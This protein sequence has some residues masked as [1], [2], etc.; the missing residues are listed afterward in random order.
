MILR[1]SKS[2]AIGVAIT[3]VA[4]VFAGWLGHSS[5]PFLNQ[6]Y[7][8]FSAPR[9]EEGFEYLTGYRGSQSF[10]WDEI[11][12]SK[13]FQLSVLK[14]RGESPQTRLGLLPRST[15]HRYI[16][17]DPNLRDSLYLMQSYA[18]ASARAETGRAALTEDFVPLA[19]AFVAAAK[20]RGIEVSPIGEIKIASLDVGSW[21]IVIREH[22]LNFL[23]IACSSSIVTTLL[24]SRKA[25]FDSA[26]A[27]RGNSS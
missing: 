23:L 4:L 27:R 26:S 6:V 5:T 19:K 24:M 2:L 22:W 12:S 11:L 7:Q 10:F 20:A 1:I 18:N 17:A 8:E 15:A 21:R 16:E 13:E 14:M 9:A 3:I 25:E